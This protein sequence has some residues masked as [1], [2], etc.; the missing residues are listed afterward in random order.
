MGNWLRRQTCGRVCGAKLVGTSNVGRGSHRPSVQPCVV[1][2]KSF[3]ASGHVR[4][5]CSEECRIKLFKAKRTQNSTFR[6]PYT[7][8]PGGGYNPNGVQRSNESR[9]HGVIWHRE[10]E[11]WVAVVFRG[12]HATMLGPFERDD[13]AAHAYDE[14]ARR[15]YGAS[16]TL[17][18]GE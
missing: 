8:L 5:T 12:R 14:E 6:N 10:T 3:E 17:N 13:E 2:G 15:R 7:V 9:Y 18:F 1:C 4:A 11:A 16:A